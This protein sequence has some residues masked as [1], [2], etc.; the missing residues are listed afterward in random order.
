[1]GEN[2]VL[3]EQTPVDFRKSRISTS[4]EITSVA[5]WKAVSVTEH[6]AQPKQSVSTLL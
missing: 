6:N 2:Y 5:N 3:C 1:M 4:E